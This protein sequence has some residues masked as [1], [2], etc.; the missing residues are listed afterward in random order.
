MQRKDVPMKNS[1]SFRSR[2]LTLGLS[3]TL[4]T[5]VS[6]CAASSSAS[7]FGRPKSAGR[8]AGT[9][10]TGLS[11]TDQA[12]VCLK[13]GLNLAAHEKDQHAIVQLKKA[14]QLDPDLKG[15]AHPLAVLYDRQG[16]FGLAEFEY[17][18]AMS[19]GR[20]YA[21][22]LNDFGYFRYSQGRSEEARRLLNQARR[23]DPQ[24]SQATI[25]LA[26]VSA[27]EGKY[28][29]AFE[30]FR[31]TVGT[32]AAHQNVGMLMLRA[33]REDEA[34]AHLDR[35]TDL[36]PSLETAHTVLAAHDAAPATAKTIVTVGYETLASP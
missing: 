12:T 7:L 8:P 15:I 28:Q 34:L 36:D 13:T 33:G 35:A 10:Q 23:L 25:N 20:P 3:V 1:D 11:H 32:A 2:V 18:R 17:Q 27:A 29:D 16:N 21:D 4:V 6:G 19:E 14:R 31:R 24:H 9:R 22:L 30:L 26:M 5:L